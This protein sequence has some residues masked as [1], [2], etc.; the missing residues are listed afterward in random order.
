MFSSSVGEVVGW[1]G[2]RAAGRSVGWLVCC[3]VVVV[4]VSH[5]ASELSVSVYFS[6]VSR[7]TSSQ[8]S[9]K[10]LPWHVCASPQLHTSRFP[11]S[12]ARKLKRSALFCSHVLYST[13][14]DAFALPGKGDCA[15]DADLA[16]S[17]PGKG[18]DP[19]LALPGNEPTDQ[20]GT[21]GV[22]QDSPARKGIN[23]FSHCVARK[24]DVHVP[25]YIQSVANGEVDEENVHK[26]GGEDDE[27]VASHPS[28]NVNRLISSR[29]RWMPRAPLGIVAKMVM[30][31]S[32]DAT[33]SSES[34]PTIC[35]RAASC[36]ERSAGS[37]SHRFLCCLPPLPPLPPADFEDACGL[38]WRC[39]LRGSPED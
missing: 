34:K 4:W 8:S 32:G 26:V 12:G 7:Q 18:I 11:L 13:R 28:P 38:C 29:A 15:G 22:S 24:V 17:L 25:M 10:T 14:T 6:S 39:C 20:Q 5:G 9:I 21:Q 37:R 30:A 23:G 35:N 33:Q 36:E 31:E 2:R 3:V 16:L 1:L 19:G 27:D